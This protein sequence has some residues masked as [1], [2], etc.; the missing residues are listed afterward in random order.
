MV[1]NYI[2]LSAIIAVIYSLTKYLEAKYIER[3]FIPLKLVVRDV[4]LVFGC[5]VVTLFLSSFVEGPIG[6][7]LSMVTNSPIQPLNTAPIAVHTS[8]PDF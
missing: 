3:T 4:M 8:P 7:F 5:S 6:Y 2:I 1:A